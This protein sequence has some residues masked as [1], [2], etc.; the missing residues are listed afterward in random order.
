VDAACP[1][2]NSLCS[3]PSIYSSTSRVAQS[4]RRSL[5]SLSPFAL[6]LRLSSSQHAPWPVVVVRLRASSCRPACVEQI[7][8]S[9]FSLWPLNR[10]HRPRRPRKRRQKLK[11]HKPS[12]CYGNSYPSPRTWLKR[13]PRAEHGPSLN[14]VV[15]EEKELWELTL[16]DCCKPPEPLLYAGIVH[17]L[18]HPNA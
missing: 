9:K 1:G 15:K 2:S 3:R 5:V 12:E 13:I 16:V 4:P 10:P 17:E 8:S 11:V 14:R 6:A 18:R 7:Q